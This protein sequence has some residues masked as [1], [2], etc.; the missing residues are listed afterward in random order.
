[1]KII[2]KYTLP[3]L[4]VL[5]LMERPSQITAALSLTAG[6]R[7]ILLFFLGLIAEVSII[8][9]TIEQILM[10]KAKPKESPLL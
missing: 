9:L 10:V 1:M 7:E 4:K 5:L 6:A 8:L 3:F 2:L